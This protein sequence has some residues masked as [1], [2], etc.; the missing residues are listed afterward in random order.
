MKKNSKRQI[1]LDFKPDNMSV[2]SCNFN[3]S[4]ELILFCTTKNFSGDDINFVCVYSMPIQTT[5]TKQNTQTKIT[6]TKCQK[7]YEIPK[8]AEV[9]SI[10]KYKKYK[11]IWLR[12]NNHIY[13]WNL[14]T[15]NTK[16]LRNI[17]EVI[18]NFKILSNLLEIQTNLKIN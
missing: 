17:H 8:G 12:L 6:K 9:L 15:S 13:E 4:N 11:K 2:Q 5:Q 3:N 1:E 14:L 18:L 7:I 16:I 10:S